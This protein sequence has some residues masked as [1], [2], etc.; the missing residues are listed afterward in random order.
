MAVAQRADHLA[1][2]EGGIEGLL[3]GL[4]GDHLNGADQAAIAHL[5]GQRVV[6]EPAHT[7]LELPRDFLH[8]TQEVTL[9]ID[10]QRLQGDRRAHRMA[11]VRVTMTEPAEIV[12]TLR[13]GVEDFLRHHGR[14]NRQIRTGQRTAQSQYPG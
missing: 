6:V 5:A 8:M 11:G 3:A 7:R 4:V 1:N 13:D 14:R 10:F 9:L 12:R 2:T